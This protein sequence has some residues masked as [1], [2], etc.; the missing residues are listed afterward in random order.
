MSTADLFATHVLPTYARLPLVPV[1]G[2]GARLWDEAG[3]SYLDFCTG[4]AVCSLGHCHPR[5]VEA[6]REQAGTLMH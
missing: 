3:K 5:L 1:R 6:I 2:A 4:I